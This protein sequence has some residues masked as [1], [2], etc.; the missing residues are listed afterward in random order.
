MKFLGI[1]SM[2]SVDGSLYRDHGESLNP[3]E[4]HADRGFT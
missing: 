3:L 2:E 1:R 4:S